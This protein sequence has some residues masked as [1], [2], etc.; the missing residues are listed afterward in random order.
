[1][2]VKALKTED[3]WFGLA[4]KEDKPVSVKSFK[5]LIWQGIYEEK[6]FGNSS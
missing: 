3:K 4:Y 6:L 1:M 5:N 2:T